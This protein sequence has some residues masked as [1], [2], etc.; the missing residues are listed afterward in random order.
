VEILLDRR[1]KE[2]TTIYPAAG[3]DSSGVAMSFEQLQRITGGRVC[4]C[5]DG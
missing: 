5:T 4:D 2:F 3:T 1:L